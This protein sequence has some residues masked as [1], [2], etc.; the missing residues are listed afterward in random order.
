[1]SLIMKT[2]R[3]ESINFDIRKEQTVLLIVIALMDVI[4]TYFK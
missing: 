1:M 4:G 2:I 3:P